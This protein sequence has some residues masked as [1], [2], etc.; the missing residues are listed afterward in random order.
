[1]LPKSFT[2]GNLTSPLMVALRPLH[3]SPL[4]GLRHRGQFLEAQAGLYPKPQ[5]HLKTRPCWLALAGLMV[6]TA[7]PSFAAFSYFDTFFDTDWT[8]VGVGGMRGNGNGSLGLTGVSGTVTGAFLFWHGPTNSSD[9]LANAMVTFNGTSVTGTN[10]G[11]S[12]NNNWG[13]VNSQ[14]YRADVSSLVAGNASY[15]LSDF[16]KSGGIEV[17]GASLYVLFDDGDN[18]NNRDL[19]VFNGNDSN[20]QSAFDNA[21]WNVQLNGI[22]YTGGDASI[23]LT[24]SDGQDFGNDEGASLN[25]NLLIPV[26]PNWQGELGSNSGNGSLWDEKTFS[27]TS[28]LSPGLNNINLV[29]TGG[30]TDALSLIVAAIDLPAGAAPP[31][32]PPPF[33]PIPEPSTYGLAGILGLAAIVALRRRTRPG[34]RPTA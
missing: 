3:H 22:N 21:G 27:V 28:L 13:F 7:A 19:V 6:G 31:T 29:T 1:M 26:G 14:A 20:I 5:M 25:G 24:V 32:E 33:T 15:S 12:H 10:I 2:K 4:I 17:N 23:R 8:S 11:L 16:I 30:L 9:P 18:S 34:Q